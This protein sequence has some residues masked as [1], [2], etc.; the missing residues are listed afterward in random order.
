[1]RS[2]S[3][4]NPS[5]ALM[6]PPFRPRISLRTLLLL[7]LSCGAAG[8]IWQ[9]RAPWQHL[10][11]MPQRA[12]FHLQTSQLL[13]NGKVLRVTSAG[14]QQ[15]D[16][17]FSSGAWT[18]T[19]KAAT[20]APLTPLDQ[21]LLEHEISKLAGVELRFIDPRQSEQGYILQL[22]RGDLGVLCTRDGDLYFWNGARV[23]N[24]HAPLRLLRGTK[25][26]YSRRF[27]L[28]DMVDCLMEV[29]TASA[30]WSNDRVDI[31]PTISKRH[32]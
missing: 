11:T 13:E 21:T 4:P 16:Y 5:D 26:I 20:I 18:D 14:G 31:I 7:S 24:L 32:T 2:P 19:E 6:E 30:M 17:R 15:M 27:A 1:M 9:N 10:S 22:P 3:T 29:D 12:N 8:L 25:Y 23:F 28:I